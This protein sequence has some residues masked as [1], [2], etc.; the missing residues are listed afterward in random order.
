MRLA[1]MVDGEPWERVASLARGAEDAGF[2]GIVFT[3]TRQAPWISVAAAASATARMELMTGIAVAF[4]RSP[5]V[6]AQLAWEL[7]DLTS[8][9]FRLGLGTQVR[10]HVERRYGAPFEPPGPRMR[11]YVQA[12]KACLRAFRREEPL[13]HHGP[14]Y[15]LSLLPEAWT[16]RPHAHGDVKIDVAAVNP[17]MCA[18]A[19]EVADGIHVHPL[20]SSRYLRGRLLPAVARG[21]ATAGRTTASVELT[22]PVFAVPGDTPEARAPLLE[23]ARAKVAFY[24]ATRNYA[25][26][27]D[28]LGYEGTSARLN[29]LLRRGDVAAMSE[30]V[31][32]EMLGHFAVIARWD[33]LAD[34]L[35]ARYGGIATRVVS[36]LTTTSLQDDPM[37]L[38][39]WGEVARALEAD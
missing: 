25:F 5:M 13:A 12:V 24:G 2:S 29:E 15:E 28:D 23:R 18:M 6:T 27:F 21:A 17:W 26:Q 3:E 30:V 36:Y 39:R 22:V 1:L 38:G 14:Y 35:R 32:D 37:A 16:P 10:A 11:D 7:A 9:R 20:H 8:G 33:E 19:A 34:A 31:S 4:A